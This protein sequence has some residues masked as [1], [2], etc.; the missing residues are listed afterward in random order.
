MKTFLKLITLIIF[1]N[2]Y[3]QNKS[4]EIIYSFNTPNPNGG[5]NKKVSNLIFNDSISIFEYD[6]NDLKKEESNFKKNENGDI[7]IK[8]IDSDEIGSF[9]HRNYKTKDIM[10]RRVKVKFSDG[11]YYKDNWLEI[12]WKIEDS[13]KK[14]ENYNCQKATCRFRG[15][16][17]ES[18]F[19]SEIPLQLGPWKFYGLPGLIL[20]TY[21]EKKEFWAIAT[22]ISFE[23]NKKIVLPNPLKD[24]RIFSYEEYKKYLKTEIEEMHSNFLAKLPKGVNMN[25]KVKTN[26]IELEWE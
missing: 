4:G 18:W 24:D 26:P 11:V 15:R 9:V 17:Y 2:L 20:E 5:S 8:L 23:G 19:T 1:S 14:I 25:L 10:V 6:K 13:F 12:N 22:K 16:N 7:D 3:S 21:D